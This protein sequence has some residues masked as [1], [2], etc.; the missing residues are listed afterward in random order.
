MKPTVLN[1]TD[2]LNTVGQEIQEILESN[3][4]SL[5]DFSD[6]IN[7][8]KDLSQVKKINK[9]DLSKIEE[10]IGIDGLSL[11]LTN[12]QTSYAQKVKNAESSYKEHLKIYNKIKHL[13]KSTPDKFNEG[14]DELNDFTDFLD[15]DDERSLLDDIKQRAALYRVSRVDI[16]DLN[17]FVWKRRGEVF[18]EEINPP[19]YDRKQFEAWID[20]GDW[21]QHLNDVNYFKSLPSIFKQFGIALILDGY[22]SKTVY[23]LVDWIDGKPLIQ[24]SDREK[25]LPVCWFTLFHEIGHILLHENH[26]IFESE[27]ESS[28]IRQSHIEK[29]ANQFAYTYLYGGND[30]RKYVFQYRNK[31]VPM[32]FLNE[33]TAKFSVNKIFVAYWI[34]KAQI[35]NCNLFNKYITSISFEKEII[36]V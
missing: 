35:K 3:E 36:A 4:I 24:I 17:L 31:E 34:K 14:I 11:Y 25:S 16:D 13:I 10:F 33:T 21:K 15:L 2:L 22:I 32:T 8:D 30:L 6:F 5:A 7:W 29:E 28:N 26:Q 18:F 9:A 12:F 1:P 27:I 23:G 19:Q 20:K